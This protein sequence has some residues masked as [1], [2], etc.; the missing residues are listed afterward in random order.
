MD[1]TSVDP[2]DVACHTVC[3]S[4][5]RP[6]LQ[7]EKPQQELRF[8]ARDPILD[9]ALASLE[10]ESTR[11][12]VGTLSDNLFLFA[13]KRIEIDTSDMFDGKSQNEST[14]MQYRQAITGLS[15]RG[16]KKFTLEPWLKPLRKGG[17]D[18]PLIGVG[19]RMHLDSIS[20]NTLV[21]PPLYGSAHFAPVLN[22]E[23]RLARERDRAFLQQAREA[24]YLPI[25]YEIQN[26]TDSPEDALERLERVLHMGVYV[27]QM[28]IVPSNPR[29]ARLRGIFSEPRI[30][31]TFTRIDEYLTVG[32]EEVPDD[33]PEVI[34]L[35]SA[36]SKRQSP[37]KTAG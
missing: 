29:S 18:G 28:T 19:M 1:T 35:D 11:G 27:S 7:T 14:F 5:V 26:L 17:Q 24:R 9:E 2:L 20:A 15:N 8:S 34:D 32:E 3:M 37:M 33:M 22:E 30:E 31:R 13:M 12:D 16:T 25:R 23:Q 36:P 6:R 21:S 10:H 4:D